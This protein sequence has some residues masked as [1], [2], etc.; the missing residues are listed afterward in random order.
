MQGKVNIKDLYNYIYVSNVFQAKESPK[1]PRFDPMTPP[2]DQDAEA[3]PPHDE[4]AFVN[5][6]SDEFLAF[7]QTTFTLY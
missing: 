1:Q 5:V 4:D 6:R 7:F 3:P 2:Q